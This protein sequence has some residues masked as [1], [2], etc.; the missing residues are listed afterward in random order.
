[1][2]LRSLVKWSATAFLVCSVALAQSTGGDDR[3]AGGGGKKL[4]FPVMIEAPLKLGGQRIASGEAFYEQTLRSSKA[5]RL[6]E[7]Y[8]IKYKPRMLD[9]LNLSGS[10]SSIALAAGTVLVLARDLTG[11]MYCAAASEGEDNWLTFFDVGYCARDNDGDGLFDQEI[12]LEQVPWRV[13]VPYEILG[14]GTGSWREA[15]L[16]YEQV[17]AADIPVLRI[18]L[19][20][21]YVMQTSGFLSFKKKPNAYFTCKLYWP[22]ALELK[23]KRDDTGGAS[24]RVGNFG[25]DTLI[26]MNLRGVPAGAGVQMK[27]ESPPVVF[28]F[29]VHEDTTASVEVS[30]AIP[31]GSALLTIAGRTWHHSNFKYQ[32]TEM[33]ILPQPPSP[34]P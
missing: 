33:A 6:K 8:V 32:A 18:R 3:D 29:T 13:R 4:Y 9:R 7:R 2:T 12:V 21:N 34:R 31:P 25:C 27:V 30:S 28:T 22:E 16:G 5:V 10:D 14:T 23:I 24:I 26:E 19:G 1:M 20:Y 17:P 11:E 15:K